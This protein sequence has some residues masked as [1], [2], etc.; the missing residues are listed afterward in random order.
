MFNQ[1]SNIKDKLVQN[2]DNE[3]YVSHRTI[4]KFTENKIHSVQKLITDNLEELEEFG[5]VRFEI[6]PRKDG[7]LSGDLPKIYFLNEPQATLILTFMRNNKVVK[8]FKIRLVK[9][10]FKMRKELQKP[11]PPQKFDPQK[12]LID[13]KASIELI[14]EVFS[15]TPFE[16]IQLDLDAKKRGE[17][18]PIEHFNIDLSDVYLLPT[19]L[20]K[21]I[22]KSAIEV[23]QLLAKSGYQV[24]VNGVWQLTKEGQ[25]LGIELQGKFQQIKWRVEAVL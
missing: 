9:D 3:L 15:C 6:E 10:F 11:T 19:E 25:E 2:I 18:S 8:A 4:A 23:N 13:T 14:R 17:V 5:S 1:N 22:G 7:S 16:M 12:V 20:G 24:K 21:L